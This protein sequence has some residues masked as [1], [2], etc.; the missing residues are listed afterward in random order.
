MHL[1]VNVVGLTI[2]LTGFIFTHLLVQYERTH[3][4]F[5]RHA[6]RIYS[7]YEKILPGAGFGMRASLGA[8]TALA[9]LAKANVAGIEEIARYDSREMVI[10]EGSDI[11]YRN[12]QFVDPAFFRIFDLEFIAGDEIAI[13]EPRTVL[14]SR[15][16]ALNLFGTDDVIG[17]TI[18]ISGDT[19]LR[20]VGVFNDLPMN[21][22]FQF[23]FSVIKSPGLDIVTSVETWKVMHGISDYENWTSLGQNYKTY[24][25]LPEGADPNE[26][27]SRLT[28]LALRNGTEELSEFLESVALRPLPAVHNY[29]WEATQIPAYQGLLVFGYILLIIAILNYI[30]LAGAKA[31]ARSREI[32]MRKV[33]G[34]AR[35]S[36]VIQFLIEGV[37]ESLLALVLAVFAL[38]VVVP[39]FNDVTG[40]V[41]EFNVFSDVTTLLWLAGIGVTVGAVAGLYPAYVLSSLKTLDALKGIAGTGR[42]GRFVSSTIVALQFTFSITLLVAATIAYAQDEFIRTIDRGFEDSD[43]ILVDRANEP[44]VRKVSARLKERFEQIDGVLKV[45]R[46]SRTPYENGGAVSNYSRSG[47]VMDEV[48]IYRFNLDDDFLSLYKI[49]LLSGRNLS[50]SIAK[51]VSAS[52]ADNKEVLEVNVMLSEMAV[53]E[54]GFQSAEDAIGQVIYRYAK[55]DRLEA[56]VTIVGV[57]GDFHYMGFLGLKPLVFEFAPMRFSAINI[58]Y[59]PTKAGQVL[60]SVD[61]AWLQEIPGRPISRTFLAD[62]K[63]FSQAIFSGVT[64]GITAFSVLAMVVACIGLYALSSFLAEQRTFE[65]GVRKVMGATTTGLLWRMTFRLVAPAAWGCLLGLPLGLTIGTLSNQ[66][67]TDQVP[68]SPWFF[69][70]PAAFIIGLAVITVA[71]HTTRVSIAHPIKALRYE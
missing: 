4:G 61:R 37:V 28:A 22:H 45:A 29:L 71:G 56:V 55:G 6:D 34:A 44:E 36:L 58:Q 20:I 53:A 67:I 42:I 3:D 63:D 16:R 52:S 2:G 18:V 38:S 7:V 66:L 11:V 49:P 59:D 26:I 13:S 69:I 33:M 15:S 40:K 12:V 48:T 27:A 51:D 23:Q 62:R 47:D 30:N 10:G 60:T 31:L 54:M 32:G 19:H 25:L 9:P 5:F 8:H 46:S 70:G 41:L 35:R 14:L 65:I 43:V 39:L 24:A 50:R 17:D 21:S 57:T 64:L 68:L 1:I